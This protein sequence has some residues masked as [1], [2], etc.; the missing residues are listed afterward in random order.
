MENPNPAGENWF[1]PQSEEAKPEEERV[2][3]KVRGLRGTEAMDVNFY[4][5][6]NGR[7]TMTSRGGNA[8]LRAGLLGWVNVKDAQGNA[9]EFNEKDWK[10]NIEA[11]SPMDALFVALDI[12][13]RTMLTETARKN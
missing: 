11:M 8:C 5:G 9:I 4:V 2:R 12:W 1:T 7:V 6:E 3:Y 13:N 10:A